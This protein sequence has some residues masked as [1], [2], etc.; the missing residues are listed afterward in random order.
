MLRQQIVI[1]LK[2]LW[3]HMQFAVALSHPPSLPAALT[4]P[5]K[6]LLPSPP[7]LGA[8]EPLYRHS[9]VGRG[10]GRGESAAVRVPASIEIADWWNTGVGGC[11]ACVFAHSSPG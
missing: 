8:S 11:L 5:T 7:L 4:P 10:R 3:V 2:L 1:A 9:T 6:L